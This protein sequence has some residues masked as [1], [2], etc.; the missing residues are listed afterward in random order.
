MRIRLM[1][2]RVHALILSP[3]HM[4][5]K[6]ATVASQKSASF[7]RRFRRQSPFSATV[8]LFCDSVDRALADQAGR[9]LVR[10]LPTICDMGVSTLHVCIH[11]PRSTISK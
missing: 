10:S 7:F 1:S 8:S 3:V 6:T 9:R 11:R 5:Q 2:R 4:S